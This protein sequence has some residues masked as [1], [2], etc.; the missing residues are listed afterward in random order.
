MNPCREREEYKC[1][2]CI[3]LPLESLALFILAVKDSNKDPERLLH[4][5]HLKSAETV[6]ERKKKTTN[7]LVSRLTTL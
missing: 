5:K 7:I 2:I 1:G 3:H 4:L 6:I